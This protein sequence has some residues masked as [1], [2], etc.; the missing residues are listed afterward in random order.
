LGAGALVWMSAVAIAQA[1]DI[2]P[3]TRMA[4]A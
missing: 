2:P 1:A 4:P 3:P